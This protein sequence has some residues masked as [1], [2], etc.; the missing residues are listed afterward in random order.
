MARN[1]EGCHSVRISLLDLLEGEGGALETRWKSTA[2]GNTNVEMG[3]HL[4]GLCD[5]FATNL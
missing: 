2:L 1:E 3:Q 4:H 5:P